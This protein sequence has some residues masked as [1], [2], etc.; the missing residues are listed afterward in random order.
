MARRLCLIILSAFLAGPIAGADNGADDYVRIARVSYIAGHVSYQHPSDVDWSAASINLPLLPEDRVYTGPDGRAEIEFDDGSVYRLAENTDIE[1][2]SLRENLVQLRILVGLSTLNVSS[3]LDFEINTPAAAFNARRKGVYRFKVAENGETEAIV[4]KG[5]LDVAN[6]EFSRAIEDGEILRIGP[7]QSDTGHLARYD[8]RDDWDEWND[9][10][11]ADRRAYASRQYVPD[12]VYAGVSELDRYG[13]WINVDVYG[14]AWVPYYVDNYWSPYSVGRWCYRPYFGWTWI[15]YEPWGWLPYHYGRWHRNSIFGW[16][17]LPGPG[18]SFNFWSPGLVS[19]YYGPGWISWCPLGPG[20][21]YNVN[22]YRYHHGIYGYQLGQLRAL[23]T[24]RPGDLYNRDAHGAFRTTDIEHFRNESFGERNRGDR[25]RNVDQPWR[26]GTLVNDRLPVQPTAA[27]FDAAPGRTFS[28]P[29]T[30]SSLPAVVRT[31]PE[32]AS[33]NRERFTRI[34]N[35]QISSLPARNRSAG[36]EAG[37]SGVR[38]LQDLMSGHRSQGPNC[39]IEC[40]QQESLRE[41]P[42][43]ERSRIPCEATWRRER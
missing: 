27:S 32:A 15:S 40:A 43:C 13:R 26:Q 5:G 38:I 1:V 37:I 29:R 17:W 41:N 31:N 4:R 21:Y 6:N 25:W 33:G 20:D 39:R 16:C 7:G 23:H 30:N 24:R 22:H 36:N 18:F 8:R 14:P 12:G 42:R 34:T 10:R 2:L 11:E 9:R 28:R 19:F 3:G 35:P